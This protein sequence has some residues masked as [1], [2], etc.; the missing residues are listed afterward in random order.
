VL[1]VRSVFEFEFV[2]GD[3]G[4]GFGGVGIDATA[5]RPGVCKSMT[6][7]IGRGIESAIS[8]VIVEDD[9]SVFRFGPENGLEEIITEHFRARE[10][11]SFVLFAG[12]QV[13]EAGRRGLL[14][15]GVEI[16]RI[17]ENGAIVLVSGQN[18][19]DDLVDGKILIPFAD[20]S[21]SLR[22]GIAATLATPDVIPGKKGTFCSGKPC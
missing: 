20:L 17:D 15:G 9:G 16:G 1:I 6:D 5:E 12:A 7:E 21:E 14:Q 4:I 18:V 19:L 3:G 10:S 8:G 11:D 13:E 2:A 22:V